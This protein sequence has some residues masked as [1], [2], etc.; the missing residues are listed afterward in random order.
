MFAASPVKAFLAA[1]VVFLSTLPAAA[2]DRRVLIVNN[3]GYTIVEFYGSHRDAR[4]WQEDILGNSVLPSGSSVTINFD[5]GTGYCIFDFRAVFSDGDVIISE[6]KNIC[7][8][9]RFTYN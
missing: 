1:A 2:L 4:T 9:A 7:E 6:N 5:D 8:L 3:T